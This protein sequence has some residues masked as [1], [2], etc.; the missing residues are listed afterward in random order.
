MWPSIG[1]RATMGGMRIIGL[2][3]PPATN[4]VR[5]SVDHG[6]DPHQLLWTKGFVVIRPL[7]ARLDDDGEL[8]VVMQVAKRRLTSR[9]PKTH[10]HGGRLRGA[11][12]PGETPV[13]RQRIAAYAIVRSVRGVLGTRNSER[14]PVP[15]VWQLP[16]GGIEAGE[17]PA[18]A[19]LREISEE[20]SQQVELDRLVDLQSDHWI[21]LTTGGV[22]EDFHALRL[23]YTATCAEPTT[24]AVRE[25]LGTTDLA[26]WVP[27]RH[28]R[29]L[30]WTAGA[31]SAL[32][33]FA[34]LIQLPATRPAVAPAA[35]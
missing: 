35:V 31:R 17:T 24:P 1:V 26:R 27:L 18:E 23:I 28:W 33:R 10:P 2:Q 11:Q 32:D 34:D 15:G 5:A 9:P 14:G 21:G 6:Q 22:W 25:V 29:G 12:P 3:P 13:K 19:V 7:S 8:V 16:G 4:V 30:P 20:T